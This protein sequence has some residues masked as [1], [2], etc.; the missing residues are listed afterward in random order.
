MPLI[1]E[2]TDNAAKALHDI[3]L[4]GFQYAMNLYNS[5]KKEE[6]K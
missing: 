5:I 3:E 4:R 2:A 6:Q 1:E